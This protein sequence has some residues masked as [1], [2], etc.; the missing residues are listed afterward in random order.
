MFQPTQQADARLAAIEQSLVPSG[1]APF[2]VCLK[3]LNNRLDD[4]CNGNP[5]NWPTS[6]IRV[7]L[8]AVIGTPQPH[9]STVYSVTF[10]GLEAQ[11]VLAPTGSSTSH[12]VEVIWYD[13]DQG[14]NPRQMIA[15]QP[16]RRS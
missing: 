11:F 13:Y 10:G 12:S 6:A 8:G 2:Q 15:P 3:T 14:Y 5:P 9:P 4:I 7:N 1:L 16:I